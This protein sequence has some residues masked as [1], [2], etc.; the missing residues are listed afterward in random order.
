VFESTLVINE[1]RLVNFH[2]QVEDEVSAG[3]SYETVQL[4]AQEC[5]KDR[6][7][8]RHCLGA[9]TLFIYRIQRTPYRLE[10]YLRRRKAH[11]RRLFSIQYL[12][13]RLKPSRLYKKLSNVFFSQ[14]IDKE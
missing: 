1:N 2:G 11:F 4:P 12:S 3:I 10:R 13:S 6:D 8:I 5:K 14:K 7:L 9:K